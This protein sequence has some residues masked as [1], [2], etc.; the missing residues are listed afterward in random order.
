MKYEVTR[1]N[2]KTY[3]ACINRGTKYSIRVNE[4]KSVEVMSKRI[5]FGNPMAFNN[6]R[7]F[8]SVESF[9]TEVKSF[10]GFGDY[11]KSVEYA[12]SENYDGSRKH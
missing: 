7:I 4:D 2:D 3:Y 9:E 11:A 1:S 10:K 8:D 12:M 6:L 5:R